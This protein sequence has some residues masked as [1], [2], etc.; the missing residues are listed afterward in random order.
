M[1]LIPVKIAVITLYYKS[2]FFW[3]AIGQYLSVHFTTRHIQIKIFCTYFFPDIQIKFSGNYLHIS[4]KNALKYFNI[5]YY[6]KF[7]PFSSTK[8]GFVSRN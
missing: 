5:L 6:S 1:H 8:R 3:T 7:P 2:V 4:S